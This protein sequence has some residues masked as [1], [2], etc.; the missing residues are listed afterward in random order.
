MPPRFA[1]LRHLPR[2]PP[3]PQR[4]RHIPCG[5]G[6]RWVE[7]RPELSCHD[8]QDHEEVQRPRS[9][10]AR[11]RHYAFCPRCFRPPVS[12]STAMSIRITSATQ[13]LQYI[14]PSTASFHVTRMRGRDA[15]ASC[16]SACGW[17]RPAGKS[18]TQPAARWPAG[19]RHAGAGERMSSSCGPL[20]HVLACFGRWPRLWWPMALR[21]GAGLALPSSPQVAAEGGFQRACVDGLLRARAFLHSVFSSVRLGPPAYSSLA[22]MPTQPR[23]NKI[24]NTSPHLTSGHG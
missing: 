24:S 8:V 9:P 1:G 11:A 2:L 22:H 21:A 7:G 19:A 12:P 16:D 5:R 20:P 18:S 4:L 17:R 6:Q 10:V 23:S 3:V 15:A 14:C 13:H